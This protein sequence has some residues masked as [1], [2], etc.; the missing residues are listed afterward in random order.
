MDKREYA[1][2]YSLER[3][4]WWFQGRK[5]IVMTLLAP[6]LRDDR[7]QTL[8]DLGCGTGLILDDLGERGRAVGVDFSELALGFC[9]DRGIRSLAQA[10]VTSLPLRTASADI[11][12]LLDITEHVPDDRGLIREVARILKP[13]G[14]ALLTVPAHQC[15]WSDH[16]RTLW[17]QRRYSKRSLLRLFEDSPLEVRRCTWAITF[18]F[19]PIVV[20]RLIQRMLPRR[21][22]P[23]THLIPLP[24]W[25]NGFLKW[26]LHVEAWLLRRINLPFGVSLVLI[27][28]RKPDAGSPH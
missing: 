8:V 17:H 1:K 22:E 28:R 26:L 21:R 11:V 16:D 7:D 27:A 4:Y 6:L 3:T 12:T 15:L 2:M 18:T 14:H 19:P 24:G 25:V 20:F 10:D 13:G 5:R 23:K 9:R